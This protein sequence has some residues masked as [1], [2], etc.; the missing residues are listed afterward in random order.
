MAVIEKFNTDEWKHLET[1]RKK[2]RKQDGSL[3]TSRAYI[4]SLI[5]TGKLKLN[6]III[7]NQT[8]YRIPKEWQEKENWNLNELYEEW[9]QNN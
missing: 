5:S 9:K 2:F 8:F 7:D 6:K 1:I 3:G 4:Q